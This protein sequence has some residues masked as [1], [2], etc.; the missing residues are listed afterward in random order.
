MSI[1]T[2]NGHTYSDDNNAATGLGAGGHRTRFIPL[3]SDVVTLANTV[4]AAQV[5]ATQ[6]VANA[7]ASLQQ[8]NS[9]TVAWEHALALIGVLGMEIANIKNR[10]LAQ[11]VVTITQALPTNNY[12]TTYPSQSI[13]FAN[14][15]PSNAYEIDVEVE[16]AELGTGNSVS[17][18]FAGVVQATSKAVNGFT[19][20]MSGSAT[21]A[22]VRWTLL[23]P[24]YV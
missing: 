17:P 10:I 24:L 13:S 20:S 1:V 18:A 2:V 8:D 6:S 16:Y 19:L 4:A 15:L 7:P 22:R 12:V 14:A 11:G 5:S 3:I 9:N 23:N 21:S